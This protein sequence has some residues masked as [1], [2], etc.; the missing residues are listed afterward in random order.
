[1][2]R[3]NSISLDTIFKTTGGYRQG[4]VDARNASPKKTVKT[5]KKKQHG[6]DDDW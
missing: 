1:M 4:V 6:A 2:A 3:D 5:I